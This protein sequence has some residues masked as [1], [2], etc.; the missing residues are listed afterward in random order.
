MLLCHTG[1]LSEKLFAFIHYTCII[2]YLCTHTIHVACLVTM[3]S[4]CISLY[5][6]RQA[7]PRYPCRTYISYTCRF[8]MWCCI[9]VDRSILILIH[10]HRKHV[11]TSRCSYWFDIYTYMYCA[12]HWPDKLAERL[13]LD[14]AHHR[15]DVQCAWTHAVPSLV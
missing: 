2:T 11:S 7:Y 3:N 4:N 10:N 13:V 5:L 15:Y 8:I 14:C 1:L 12:D 6:Y 9:V